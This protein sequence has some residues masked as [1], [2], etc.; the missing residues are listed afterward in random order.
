MRRQDQHF[1][2]PKRSSETAARTAH[3]P[4]SLL[5]S[6]LAGLVAAQVADDAARLAA[7][8]L[9]L[10]TNGRWAV[11]GRRR[12]VLSVPSLAYRICGAIMQLGRTSAYRGV[13]A[14]LPPA[15]PNFRLTPGACTLHKRAGVADISYS[16]ENSRSWAATIPAHDTDVGTVRGKS[17]RSRKPDARGATCARSLSCQAPGV[18]CL[19]PTLVKQLWSVRT[20]SARTGHKHPLAG[21]ILVLSNDWRHGADVC[22][23]RGQETS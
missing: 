6:V 18:P 4:H 11:A 21:K 7:K 10:R 2:Q 23:Q 8:V 1:L 9:H 5:H 16:V 19:A 3:Q 13:Q 22:R 15:Q 12:S 17:V 20:G 14:L